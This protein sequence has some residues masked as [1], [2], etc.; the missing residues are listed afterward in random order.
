VEGAGLLLPTFTLI[1]YTKDL[2]KNISSIFPVLVS[3]E[4]H[5]TLFY[6]IVHL[7]PVLAKTF[8]HKVLTYVEYRAVVGALYYD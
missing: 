7:P 8:P 3:S 5:S 2:I 6:P 4:S 1:L